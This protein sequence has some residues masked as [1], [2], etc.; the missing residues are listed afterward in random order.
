MAATFAPGRHTPP[1]HRRLIHWVPDCPGGSD[2]DLLAE[3]VV[4]MVDVNCGSCLLELARLE[5]LG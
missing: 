5:V 3:T 1:R 4:Q 2:G